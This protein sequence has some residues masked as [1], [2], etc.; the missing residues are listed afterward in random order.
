MRHR[1]QLL[2]WASF[3]VSIPQHEKS[4]IMCEPFVLLP[5]YFVAPGM[6]GS[7]EWPHGLVGGALSQKALHGYLF[8]MWTNWLLRSCRRLYV[9]FNTR[10]QLVSRR[11]IL[12]FPF[13][14]D[15]VMQH[16][17]LCVV[18]E[19]VWG[20]GGGGSAFEDGGHGHSLR[21]CM[22]CHSPETTLHSLYRELAWL[23]QTINKD[24][25]LPKSCFF[26]LTVFY[27]TSTITSN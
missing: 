27:H 16:E 24:V 13:K 4:Q 3:P 1:E 9:C 11:P 19:G 7:D 2:H 25:W 10:V 12:T 23:F 6:Y 21:V 20:W 18:W 15:Q 8:S 26:L 22:L 14:M 17:S 5:I